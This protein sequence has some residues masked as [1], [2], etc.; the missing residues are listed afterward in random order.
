MTNE[1][2]GLFQFAAKLTSTVPKKYKGRWCFF[3]G[4]A[5]LLN[6][7]QKETIDIDVLTKDQETY[8][9]MI[10]LMQVLGM[11]LGAS[12]ENYSTFKTVV[13]T[14]TEPAG[15][16]VDLLLLTSKWLK[17]LK[18]VWTRLEYKKFGASSL[19]VLSPIHLILLKILVNSRRSAGDKKKERDFIDVRQ[20]I[21][22]RR[23]SRESIISEAVHQ[24]LEELTR[25]FLDKV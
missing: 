5:Y 9:K 11:Q 8:R 15:L 21:L 24:G 3:A 18:G 20:L 17:D 2:E 25:D 16:T 13:V 7:V 23:V 19:P 14:Q 22:E 10:D 12:T 4:F 1:K 6:G